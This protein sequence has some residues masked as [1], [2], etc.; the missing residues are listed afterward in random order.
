MSKTVLA[1][2]EALISTLTPQEISVIE[3][4]INA[5]RSDFSKNS[6]LLNLFQSLYEDNYTRAAK[7]FKRKLIELL[8]SRILDCLL[9]DVN[10]LRNGKYL[11]S[12]SIMITTGK[13]CLKVQLLI[14]R[15]MAKRA[16]Q[17]AETCI[18]RCKS[19]ED[20]QTLLNLLNQQ[21]SLISLHANHSA[22]IKKIDEV[23]VFEKHLT[24]KRTA[25]QLYRELMLKKHLGITENLIDFVEKSLSLLVG[26]DSK[27]KFKTLST[28]KAIFQKEL[29]ELQGRY[30]EALHTAV[31][32]YNNCYSHPQK[33]GYFNIYELVFEQARL[34]FLLNR[35]VDCVFLLEKSISKIPTQSP[36][37]QQSSELLFAIKFS[38][39]D[40]KACTQIISHIF[41]NLSDDSIL[42]EHLNTNWTLFDIA[43]SFKNKNYSYC[44]RRLISIN[45][46]AD[47][48]QS[49]QI[50]VVKIMVLI[51]LEMLDEADKTIEA[52]RKY[53]QRN[54]LASTLE[55]YGMALFFKCIVQLK[56][57]GYNFVKLLD[58]V[59][60]LFD[61]LSSKRNGPIK[62]PQYDVSL[63]DYSDWIKEKLGKHHNT[64]NQ[65]HSIVIGYKKEKNYINP[66]TKSMH[67][68]STI[69]SNIIA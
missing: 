4:T 30:P 23:T 32:I 61:T 66:F 55:Q 28:I 9:M 25:L 41:T 5:T 63:F 27:I 19:N 14:S 42:P 48:T 21:L 22:F 52:F 62:S 33:S 60:N 31:S 51:E 69:Q 13:E 58:R 45:S 54:K 11:N 53:I 37:N 10:L 20:Y 2:V 56:Y 65:R 44:H 68:H 34:C 40:F 36:F 7:P 57:S 16:Y 50:R 29:Y 3:D 17:V 43:V 59:D 38:T 1:R 49:I 46:P 15:G 24:V 67:T 12:T 35:A 18:E 6:K 64:I 26:Y 39:G 47:L 8:E